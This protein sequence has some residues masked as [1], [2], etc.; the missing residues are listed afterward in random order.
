MNAIDAR[1][2]WACETPSD[3]NEH[4]P[5][6]FVYAKE[7]SRIT[8]FGVRH[9]VSTSAW[10]MARPRSL[11]CY[12][13]SRYPSVDDIEKLCIQGGINF[14]F[15][16]E[17]SAEAVIDVTDLLF[18][19]TVHNAMQLTFELANTHKQVRK[20]I[21]MHDTETYGDVGEGEAEG[22]NVALDNFLKF[23]RDW[24]LR[25]KHPNNNGLTIL[26]RRR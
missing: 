13:I 7:C 22:L 19:D 8:E 11:V 26:Q 9:G 20:Y 12:D 4:I 16:K 23:N 25:A 17:N 2:K 6:M 24:R 15:C 18:I 1:F 21:I 3:I 10:L 14:R 5:T